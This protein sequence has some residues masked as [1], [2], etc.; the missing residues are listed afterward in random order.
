MFQAGKLGLRFVYVCY[1][2]LDTIECNAIPYGSDMIHKGR[3]LEIEVG[4]LITKIN[5]DSGHV[6]CHNEWV[7]CHFHI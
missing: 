3:N 5:T 6:M 1:I 4:A 7:W 2:W